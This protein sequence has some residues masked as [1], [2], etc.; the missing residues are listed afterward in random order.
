MSTAGR[1]ERADD[2][3]RGIECR[4]VGPKPAEGKVHIRNRVGVV[5]LGTLPKGDRGNN[6]THGGEGFVDQYVFIS[7]N[8]VAYPS[9]AMNIQ[10]RGERPCALWLVDGDLERLPIYL[11][12]VD[13]LRMERNRLTGQ[14]KCAGTDDGRGRRCWRCWRDDHLATPGQDEGQ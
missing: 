7:V 3:R 1:A 8:V 14:T 10:D 2:S 9:S 13:L 4:R 5:V 12:V 6:H 11:Q